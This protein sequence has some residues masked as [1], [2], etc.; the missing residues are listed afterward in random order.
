MRPQSQKIIAIHASHLSYQ[1]A[2]YCMKNSD[3]PFCVVV[4]NNSQV[5]QVSD[6]IRTFLTESHRD[7]VLTLPDWET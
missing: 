5:T 4:K 1:L 7:R 6:E 3:R 2:H